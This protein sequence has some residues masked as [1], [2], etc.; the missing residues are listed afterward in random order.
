MEKDKLYE[1]TENI[2]RELHELIDRELD[3]F[4]NRMKSEES[5]GYADRVRPLNI[6]AV[7]FKGTKPVAVCLPDGEQVSCRTWREAAAIILRDC[8]K[9]KH[10]KLLDISGKVFGRSRVIL[11]KTDEGMN[12]PIKIGDG[13]Y[14][15]SYFDTEYLLKMMK[16][17]V[18]EKVGYDYS[19]IQI[20]IR[21]PQET[22]F[23]ENI[24]EQDNMEDL[25]GEETDED[26][27]FS[28][29]M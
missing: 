29:M 25:P 9:K 5:T 14:F 1:Y 23:T 12:K 6:P 16:E 17:N 20:Q 7:F 22:F 18:L 28:L 3:D 8:D 15:E 13:I 4:V 26:R 21:K 24:A 11:G 19:S 2:R 10:E 27:S